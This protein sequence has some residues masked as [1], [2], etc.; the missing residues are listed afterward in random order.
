MSE[1]ITVPCTM[2]SRRWVDVPTSQ[3][4]DVQVR[5]AGHTG[6]ADG[7]GAVEVT[8][9]CRP[10]PTLAELDEQGVTREESDRA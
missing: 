8:L 9:E 5:W 7:R 6:T 1:L 4:P 3:G 10:K 2:E